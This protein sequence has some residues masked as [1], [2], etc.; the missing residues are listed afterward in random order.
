MQGMP[1]GLSRYNIYKM[2]NNYKFTILNYYVDLHGGGNRLR[3]PEGEARGGRQKGTFN[4][5]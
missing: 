2:Y 3:I 4:S 1:V 5:S